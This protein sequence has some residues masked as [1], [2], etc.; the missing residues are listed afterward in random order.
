MGPGAKS[1]VENKKT[2]Q[3]KLIFTLKVLHQ[4]LIEKQKKSREVL[5]NVRKILVY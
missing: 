4:N 3:V 5:E 1:L 2:V